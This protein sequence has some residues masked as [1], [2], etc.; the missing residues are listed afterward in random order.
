MKTLKPLAPLLPSKIS[1]P[2]SGP[3]SQA[4]DV[5][6]YVPFPSCGMTFEDVEFSLKGGAQGDKEWT[7]EWLWYDSASHKV[8][9]YIKNAEYLNDSLKSEP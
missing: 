4:Y 5:P 2:K 6:R 3:I 9:F 7:E 1:L 8:I